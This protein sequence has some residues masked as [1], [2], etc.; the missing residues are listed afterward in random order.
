MFVQNYVFELG[1]W[2]LLL[3]KWKNI[4]ALC[5]SKLLALLLRNRFFFNSFRPKY[6]LFEHLNQKQFQHNGSGF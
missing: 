3:Q 4:C 6:S 2:I 5:S 1:I